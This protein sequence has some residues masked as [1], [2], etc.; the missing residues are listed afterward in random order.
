M[1]ELQYVVHFQ[2]ML[3]QESE[4]RRFQRNPLQDATNRPYGMAEP[5]GGLPN[6][7]PQCGVAIVVSDV[8]GA[9]ALNRCTKAGLVSLKPT[10]LKFAFP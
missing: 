6:V 1:L 8:I 9:T 10:Y 7:V 4:Q 5:I 3:R 2:P